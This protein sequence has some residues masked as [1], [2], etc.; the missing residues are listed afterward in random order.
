MSVSRGKIHTYLGM[1]LDSSIPGQVQITML[2]YIQEIFDVCNKAE[3][4]GKG[5]EPSAASDN[6]FM[7]DNDCEN[8]N[9]AKKEQF[10]T[11]VAITIYAT[12]RTRLDTYT[13]STYLTTE[14][15]KPN[16]DDW[17][18]LTHLMQY[19]RAT[20][21]LPLTLSALESGMLKWWIDG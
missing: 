5:K 3:S 20:N 7:I 16:K 18:K 6:H 2:D 15:G 11:A 14:V 19:L 13:A 12:K 8:L 9:K 4:S 10:Y 21:D 17:A 1:K